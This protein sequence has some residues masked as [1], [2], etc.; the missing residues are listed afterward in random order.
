MNTQP[1][2]IS[3]S[4]K[5]GSGKDTLGAFIRDFAKSG[6]FTVIRRGFGDAL[7]EEAAEAVCEN[8]LRG[9]LEQYATPEWQAKIVDQIYGDTVERF[10]PQQYTQV[11]NAMHD[12]DQK[13]RFRFLMQW[14]GTEF[15]RE[16]FGQGYW[17]KR[18][19]RWIDHVAMTNAGQPLMFIVPDDRFPNEQEFLE[20]RG[21]FTMRIDRPSADTGDT[22]IGETALDDYRNFHMR[23]ENE[24]GLDELRAAAYQ[25]FGAAHTFTYGSAPL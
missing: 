18:L 6:N 19:K 4:G 9:I 15:R 10:D 12:R 23:L 8:T 2:L 21:F 11:L 16:Q 24:K 25:A 5:R 1:V 13:E 14:W 22:H 17:L 3:I 20:A 7:K